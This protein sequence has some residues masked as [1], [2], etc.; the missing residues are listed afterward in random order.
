VSLR[1]EWRVWPAR[2]QPTTVSGVEVP[3]GIGLGYR[4]D[5]DYIEGKT[6]RLERMS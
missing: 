1:A 4:V 2:S 6:V 5:V 3:T